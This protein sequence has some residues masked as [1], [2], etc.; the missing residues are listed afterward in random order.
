MQFFIEY[1]PNE[2]KLKFH[3]NGYF[4]SMNELC[5]IHTLHNAVRKYGRL[6]KII[7]QNSVV[8]SHFINADNALLYIYC[9]EYHSS[10]VMMAN[11]PLN[12]MMHII[13]VYIDVCIFT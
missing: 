3:K 9:V 11:H 6:I 12:Y 13:Y 4:A 7:L 1:I 5:K 8:R 10:S 2:R